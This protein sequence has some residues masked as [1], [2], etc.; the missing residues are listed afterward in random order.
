MPLV[1]PWIDDRT[2]TEDLC[3]DR[4][5][6]VLHT[7]FGELTSPG[8]LVRIASRLKS[9]D[10]LWISRPAFVCRTR[11]SNGLAEV[12]TFDK[13][14]EYVRAAVDASRM[15]I[16]KGCYVVWEGVRGPFWETASVQEAVDVLGLSVYYA[17]GCQY[18]CS[19]M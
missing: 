9:G 12:M 8:G 19:C 5:H 2:V 10:V 15:A 1:I 11:S 3:D 6:V 17:D 18:G 14:D 13:L 4:L 16:K 7:D